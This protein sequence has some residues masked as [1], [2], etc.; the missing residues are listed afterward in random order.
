ME[1]TDWVDQCGSGEV[2]QNVRGGELEAISRNEEFI[3]LTFA[4]LM[5][6]E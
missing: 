4:V 6:P 2:V 1:L 5:S 3:N